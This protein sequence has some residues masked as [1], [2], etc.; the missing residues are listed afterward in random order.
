[1]LLA[2]IA[3]A[4]TLA[5]GT[6]GPLPTA[7]PAPTSHLPATQPGAGR[8]EG[9]FLI[10]TADDGTRAVYFVAG[11]ARHSILP[12]DMQLELELNPLWPLRYVDPDE[13]LSLP[14]GAPIANA[15]T[16]LVG[17][18]AAP[19]EPEQPAP[20]PAEVPVEQPAPVA[21][22]A[23]VE[24]PVPLRAEAPVEQ[25][26]PVATE[27]P[28]GEPATYVV[29]RGDSAFLIA[30]QFGIDQATL[31]AANGI[32]NPS[33]VYAGQTLVIPG[34]A[35]TPDVA[36]AP[37]EPAPVAVDE[38]QAMADT[39][40]EILADTADD[41]APA[42]TYTVKPGDSAF[43]IARQFGIPQSALLAANG[44]SNPSRVYAG[45]VLTIPS[46]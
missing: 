16:G 38:P 30:R 35:A 1:V 29:R 5:L 45:Q 15:R 42:A 18:V 31:L 32:T 37:S 22:E 6:P 28:V 40:E 12:A 11:N 27:S 17:A 41:G 34:T 9:V 10:T 3:L 26:V 33:R 21:A 13:A 19:P 20:V 4:L 8:N 39:A 43:L 2:V 46:S 44:I 23:P 14:E 25:S 36:E 7:N 24:P